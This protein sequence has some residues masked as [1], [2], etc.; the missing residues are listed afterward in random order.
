M[1]RTQLIYDGLE[2]FA[3]LYGRKWYY[4]TRQRRNVGLKFKSANYID[5][6]WF[7]GQLINPSETLYYAMIY[8]QIQILKE[9][10]LEKRNFQIAYGLK[11]ECIY[12][13]LT[14]KTVKITDYVRDKD[15]N[16]KSNVLKNP[17]THVHNT[18][19]MWL[20]QTE[21]IVTGKQF[22]IIIR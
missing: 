12:D 17:Y 16:I 13:Y 1:N 14:W 10:L 22:V 11:P 8:I 18:T 21:H 3:S 9:E 5:S 6:D 4:S 7:L 19:K 20:K 2:K 15:G